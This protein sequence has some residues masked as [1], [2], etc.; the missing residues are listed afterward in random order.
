MGH[1]IYRPFLEKCLA[2]RSLALSVFF[3]AFVLSLSLYFGGWVKSSFVPQV[4]SDRISLNITL[5]DGGPFDEAVKLAERAEAAAQQLRAD[6]KID[7]IRT[8]ARAN[9]AQ[10]TLGV[11][12]PDVSRRKLSWDWRELIGDVG[13][14][15]D[16]KVG[17][18]I[19]SSGSP[20][21]FEL[22]ATTVETLKAATEDLRTTLGAYDGVSNI[23]SSLNSPRQEIELALKPAAEN[24]S[25]T[26]NDLAKQVRQGFHGAEV[27]RIP[28]DGED[29]KVIVRYPES[30]RISVDNLYDM[31]IRTSNGGEVP[32]ATVA[33]VSFVTGYQQIK[34]LD[35]RRVV[36]I[37]ADLK[38][39]K[40]SAG[41]LSDVIMKDVAPPA[42][43]S[44]SGL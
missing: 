15:E 4:T 43:S 18:T 13:N 35:R 9:S 21:K 14:V 30:E 3:V 31:R 37:T 20:I 7:T 40:L 16:Y 22:T 11:S 2:A 23:R 42:A 24:L 8:V 17:Y 36:E 19:N 28:R 25:I 6:Y 5:P 27:Q 34:R 12:D 32:F 33:D 38:P 44:V 26:L 29:V 41:A 39:G 1:N 10:V